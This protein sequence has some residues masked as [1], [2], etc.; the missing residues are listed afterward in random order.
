MRSGET[1]PSIRPTLALARRDLAIGDSTV[2]QAEFDQTIQIDSRDAVAHHE[3][4]VLLFTLKRYEA[5]TE[6]FQQA[7]DDEPY[8]A[9]PY[10]PLSY[11]RE[12][13]GKDSVA[14]ATYRRFIQIARRLSPARSSWPGSDSGRP[15]PTDT[16]YG[17]SLSSTQ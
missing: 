14:I 6:Q 16:G 17:S 7:V 15:P 12:S 13:E 8:F 5:A 10:F 9:K 1:S 11:L 3:Y 2:A 4:G